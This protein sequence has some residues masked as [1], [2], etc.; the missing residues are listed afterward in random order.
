VIALLVLIYNA[1]VLES[2]E[3]ALVL[4]STQLRLGDEVERLAR[5]M[6]LKVPVLALKTSEQIGMGYLR[7][8][9]S[10]LSA[11]LGSLIAVVALVWSL[12]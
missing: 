6:K 1:V 9:I 8:S 5:F 12:F 4:N 7:V 2:G 11:Y 3:L 10:C